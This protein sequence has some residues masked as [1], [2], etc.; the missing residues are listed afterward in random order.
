MKN[1]F[2][3]NRGNIIWNL[4]GIDVS[5]N[6]FTGEIP[7][8]IGSLNMIKVLNHSH[9]ILTGPIL[10]TFSNLKEIQSL[11]LSYNKLD[12]KIPS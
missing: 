7:R 12:G 1:V 3:F 2:L 6:N 5:C 11:D 8:E 9:N 4:T 10:P